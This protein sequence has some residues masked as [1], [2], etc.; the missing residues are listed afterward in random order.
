MGG[1]ATAASS[2]LDHGDTSGP[3][4]ATQR[5]RCKGHKTQESAD[6]PPVLWQ[7]AFIKMT[8]GALGVRGKRVEVGTLGSLTSWFNDVAGSLHSPDA[9]GA[10]RDPSRP[11]PPRFGR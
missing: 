6:P 8:Q 3:R 4:Q 9:L 11:S 10:G 7:Q 1:P 2:H 5:A